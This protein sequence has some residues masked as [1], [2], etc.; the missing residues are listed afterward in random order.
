MTICKIALVE[1]QLL[2]TSCSKESSSMVTSPFP[3]VVSELP[4]R[5]HVH[6]SEEPSD[7]GTFNPR[8][9]FTISVCRNFASQIQS[10]N[11]N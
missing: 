10:E 2:T 6:G 3:H 9:S 4:T 7:E 8:C 1:L 5:N 11:Q